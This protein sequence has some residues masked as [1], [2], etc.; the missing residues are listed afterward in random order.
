LVETSGVEDAGAGVI[1]RPEEGS[2]GDC[3]S[4]AAVSG[5]AGGWTWREVILADRGVDG[6]GHY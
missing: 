2:C 4:C 1:G 5:G 6:R 3:R